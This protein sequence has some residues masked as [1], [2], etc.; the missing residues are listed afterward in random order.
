[1]QSLLVSVK[2]KKGIGEE[3]AAFCARL[4]DFLQQCLSILSC[5]ISGE[6][7]LTHPLVCGGLFGFFFLAALGLSCGMWDL[8]LWRVGSSLRRWHLSSCGPRAQ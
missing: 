1:M 7:V 5:F 3:G 6:S 8:S 4:C 2:D